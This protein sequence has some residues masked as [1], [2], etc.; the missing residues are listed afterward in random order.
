IAEKLGMNT[1]ELR[2][3]ITW[4]RREERQFLTSEV[5]RLANEGF[6]NV[7]IGKKLNISEKTVRNYRSNEQP[8]SQKQWDNINDAIVKGVEKTGYLD[9]GMGVERQ[10]G[11]PRSKFNSVVNQLVK[12]KGYYI[13]QVYVRRLSDPKH[14]TTVKVL[15]KEPDSKKVSDNSNNIRPLDSWS[16]D[17]GLTIKNIKKPEMVDL[18]R[19]HI[20]Y[21][22]DGGSDKDGLIELKPGVSDLDL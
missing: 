20:R 8:P 21:A 18:D 15:S 9:V 4:A 16:D 3:N 11:V 22:E 12:E 10:I 14:W 1:T 6:N 5:N 2:N 7:E 13:H 17:G 19:I